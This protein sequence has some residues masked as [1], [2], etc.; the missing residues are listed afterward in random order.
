[1]PYFDKLT[2]A[3]EPVT[4]VTVGDPLAAPMH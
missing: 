3:G 2:E 1:M 4:Q